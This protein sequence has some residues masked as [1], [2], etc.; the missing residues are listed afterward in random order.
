M[1]TETIRNSILESDDLPLVPID[2]DEWGV[3]LFIRPL[4]GDSRFRLSQIA[5]R[6]AASEENHY[7][8]EAY[9]CE[10]LVSKDGTK[11]FSLDDRSAL[12][13]KNPELIERI[14]KRIAEA[15]GMNKESLE[16]AEKK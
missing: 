1:N 6:A 13:S 7:I 2:I 11:V 16:E 9:V 15:S 5:A 12:A 3:S 14:W 8:T 4:D 10:G